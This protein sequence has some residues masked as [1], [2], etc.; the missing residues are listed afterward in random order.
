M[1]KRPMI[2]LSIVERDK[3]KKLIKELENLN[4]RVNFQTVGFGTAPTEMMDIFGLGSNDKDI[5]ISL[6][7]KDEVLDLM[8]NFGTAFSSHSKYN[9]L[10]IILE[11][12][13][14]SRVLTE[15]LCMK[16]DKSIEKGNSVMKNEHHNNLI[17]I[18]VNEGYSENVM[19]VARKAGAVGGTVI[20]GRLADIEQFSELT[21]A[22]IDGE[23]ELLCILAPVKTSKQIMEDVNSEFGFSSPANGIIFAVPTEKAYK[24]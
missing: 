3:G 16:T 15:L 21:N 20:K 11:V 2:L 4:I 17:I 7:E 22:E 1:N 6:A 8:S 14:A 24:I 13:A 10:I 9:G 5:V 23:R 12:S 19:Q 18:S